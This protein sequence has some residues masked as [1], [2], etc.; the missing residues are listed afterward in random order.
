MSDVVA[1]AALR[2]MDRKFTAE[3][4]QALARKGWAL[5]DGSY[6]IETVGDLK[7]AIQAFGRTKARAALKRLICKRARSLNALNLV[8]EG[9]CGS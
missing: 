2:E 8:P 7:N 5:P 4:R 1:D 9:W 3:Q 6:P